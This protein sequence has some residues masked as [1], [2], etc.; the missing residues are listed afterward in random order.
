MSSG[1]GY[2]Q[3]YIV[4]AVIDTLPTVLNNALLYIKKAF[5]LTCIDISLRCVK[6]YSLKSYVCT[7]FSNSFI[8]S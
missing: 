4:T 6:T 7:D 1:P 8:H 3:L 5:R 2:T